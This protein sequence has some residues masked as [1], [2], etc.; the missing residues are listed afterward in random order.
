MVAEG[1]EGKSK[2]DTLNCIKLKQKKCYLNV[3]TYN[4]HVSSVTKKG[5]TLTIPTFH[6]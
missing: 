4:K 5:V 3:I 6:P 1:I 2:E